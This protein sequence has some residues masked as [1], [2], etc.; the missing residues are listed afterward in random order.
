MADELPERS[1]GC[2]AIGTG[3]CRSLTPWLGAM[4]IACGL[5]VA[6]S[7]VWTWFRGTASTFG[8]WSGF[9][10]YADRDALEISGGALMM[11]FDADGFY[12]ALFGPFVPVI[13][14]L[15]IGLGGLAVALERSRLSARWIAPAGAVIA[16]WSLGAAG[17]TGGSGVEPGGDIG[18]TGVRAWAIG[19]A[20]AAVALA[21]VSATDRPAPGP[22]LAR[23]IIDWAPIPAV[24]LAGA[25]GELLYVAEERDP[26]ATGLVFITASLAAASPAAGTVAALLA[27]APTGRPLGVTV[28]NASALVLG[29]VLFAVWAHA[30]VA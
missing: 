27:I 28:V 15:L 11:G 10:L 9:G 13:V 6:V 12:N 20:V 18:G 24:L 21:V 16:L 17:V 1:S 26:F 5:V 3:A 23:R 2:R 29:I 22:A 25:F 19:S 4:T 14:G 30:A 7:P 8:T